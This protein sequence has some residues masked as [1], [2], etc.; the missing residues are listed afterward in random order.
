MIRIEITATAY[1]VLAPSATRVLLE[2][3]RGP[4]GGYYLRLDRTTLNNLDAAR[5]P[6]ETYSEAILR[7]AKEEAT[8]ES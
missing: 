8:A 3:Y 6:A 2:P 1:E 4:Q 7:I 5:G